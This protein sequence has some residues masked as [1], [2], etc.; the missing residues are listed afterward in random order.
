MCPDQPTS[1][2]TLN[3]RDTC[4]SGNFG[5][6]V[7]G[8]TYQLSN[9][10]YAPSPACGGGPTP[11]TTPLVV[12]QTTTICF[13][14]L[15]CPTG[16][17]LTTPEEANLCVS[18]LGIQTCPAGFPNATVVAQS[19]NDYRACGQCAC[20][21]SLTCTLNG[22]ILHNDSACGG[23]P[24]YVMTATTGCATGPSNYPLNAIIADGV[25]AG[26]PTGVETTPSMPVGGVE[27]QSSTTAT[28]C[29][30]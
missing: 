8:H 4:S 14:N 16:A 24:P 29:C 22:V 20:A 18:K 28:V 1:T 26:S 30:K 3:Y 25:S 9:P 13:P 27:L 21:S 11:T 7:T 23:G 5:S 15:S 12:T 6:I 10:T 19:Y 2:V 17:C